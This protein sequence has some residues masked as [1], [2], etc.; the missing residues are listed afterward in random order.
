[1]DYAACHFLRSNKFSFQNGMSM[2]VKNEYFVF[3]APFYE[4]VYLRKCAQGHS[5]N[6][7]SNTY[8]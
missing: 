7:F 6:I 2:F 8:L 1:M 5:L 4:L 3:Q